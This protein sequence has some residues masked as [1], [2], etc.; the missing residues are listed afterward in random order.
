MNCYKLQ[1]TKVVRHPML[2]KSHGTIIFL[3]H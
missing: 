2:F 3:Y 1:V